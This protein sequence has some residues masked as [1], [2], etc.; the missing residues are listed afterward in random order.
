MTAI[1]PRSWDLTTDATTVSGWSQTRLPFEP[2]DELRE[3]RAALRSAL[4]GLVSQPRTGLL[5]AYAAPDAGVVDVENVALY[6]IGA[7]SYSHLTGGASTAAGC[8]APT[9]GTTSPTRSPPCLNGTTTTPASWPK[10]RPPSPYQ[11]TA[12]ATGGQHCGP[13]CVAPRAT[14]GTSGRSPL[15]SSCQEVGPA[16][17]PP[18]RSSLCSTGYSARST[19]TTAATRLSYSHDCRPSGRR[20]LSGPPSVTPG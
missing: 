10:S 11:H 17:Q 9:N 13:P 1:A 19:H 3:Y 18:R 7:G 5:A 4:R 14:A 16:R 12:P 6:N 20:L 2:R 8:P 15:R